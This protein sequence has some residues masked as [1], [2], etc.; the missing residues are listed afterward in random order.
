[1]LD[2]AVGEYVGKPQP[3]SNLLAALASVYPVAVTLG[4]K[5][6]TNFMMPNDLTLS[7]VFGAQSFTP[8]LRIYSVQTNSAVGGG[9]AL[10]GSLRTGASTAYRPEHNF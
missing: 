6:K 7:S 2:S 8:L 4:Q 5:V 1:M 3:S 9:R 10:S